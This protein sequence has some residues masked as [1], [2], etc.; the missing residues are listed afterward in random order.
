MIAGPNGAGKTTLAKELIAKSSMLYEFINADEIA[1]GLAPNHPE[2]VALMASKLMITRIRELLQ[3]GRSF[4]FETTLAA[5][6]Y[7]KHLKAAKDQGYDVILFFLWLQSPE[8]AIKR[9]MQRVEQGGHFVPK[10]T[11]KKRYYLGLKNLLNSYLS[12]AD[13]AVIMNNS[14]EEKHSKI[15][16]R[17]GS[18][19][20]VDVLDQ[21]IWKKINEV[22]YGR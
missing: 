16:A 22:A 13:M 1:K 10:E 17:Q 3:E 12:L 19:G 21:S 4:A 20:I 9:V 18:S 8:Q 2:H 5:T 14:M 11:I 7:L 15:I 6:N